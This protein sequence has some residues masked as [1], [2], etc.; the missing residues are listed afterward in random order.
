MG[1]RQSYCALFHDE[2]EG[3]YPRGGQRSARNACRAVP[4]AVYTR[5][6]IRIIPLCDRARMSAYLGQPGR[7]PIRSLAVAS[8]GNAQGPV[9][10]ADEGPF[11]GKRF[12]GKA[13]L[14]AAGF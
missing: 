11:H 4:G 8:H 14:V 13:S 7:A 9:G 6:A 2:C 3:V 10:H 12:M 1:R 5:G